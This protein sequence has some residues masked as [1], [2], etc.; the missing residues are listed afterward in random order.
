[1]FGSSTPSPFTFGASTTPVAVGNTFGIGAPA[2]GSSTPM[3]GFS[4]GGQ[5]GT[6]G[7]ATPFASSLAQNPLGAQNQSTPF[8]FSIPGTAESKPAFGGKASF[9]Q[10]DR[11]LWHEEQEA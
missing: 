2:A 10:C 9:E 11:F 6:V 5:S 4:F 7:A 8:A 3:V 1:M